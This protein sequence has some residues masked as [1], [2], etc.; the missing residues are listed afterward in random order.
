MIDIRNSCLLIIFLG[1]IKI[2][3]AMLGEKMKVTNVDVF[4]YKTA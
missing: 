1:L 2:T 4:L 3:I